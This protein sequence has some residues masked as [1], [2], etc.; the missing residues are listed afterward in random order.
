MHKAGCDSMLKVYKHTDFK[1]K[2]AY[3]YEC[4]MNGNVCV[5]A[6]EETAEQVL[7][8]W[9]VLTVNTNDPRTLLTLLFF[10]RQSC[11]V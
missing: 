3:W 10:N 7:K 1:Q 4:S 11:S 9:P 8:E 6:P 2:Y 5:K